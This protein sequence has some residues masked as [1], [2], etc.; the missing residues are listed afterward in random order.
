[1]NNRRTYL[2]MLRIIAC[3]LVIFNH[4]SGYLAYQHSENAVQ[5]FYY[6]GFTMFTRIN[7]P[8]FF[9]ISGSLLLSKDTSYKELFSKR[10][11]RIVLTLLCASFVAYVV[12]IRKNITSFDFTDFF[13]K[14]LSGKHVNAYWYLY[15]Y[16][17]FL[18]MLPLF[19]RIAK[20][21]DHKD[22]ILLVALHF[23]FF[24]FL[25]L[26]NYV[27]GKL[28]LPKMSVASDFSVP[29][30]NTKAL[31]YP[32]IGYYIDQVFDISKLNRK[33]V[34][35]LP[36]VI[37][38]GIAVSS[39]FTYYQGIHNKFT[40]DYVQSFDYTTAIAVFLLVK[41]IF[42]NSK[43]L[44]QCRFLH[45]VI[46]LIGSLTLGIYLM[47]PVLKMVAVNRFKKVITTSDPIAYSLIWCVFSMLVCGIVTY[48]LKKLPVIK[49]LL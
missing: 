14:L 6:M 10:I 36:G 32:L 18:L 29:L 15:A 17:A 39:V 33:N 22:F 41:Y 37:I 43:A 45:R 25:P 7:V 31:F 20:Q 2:D 47:D 42:T 38:F 4:L 12:S 8:I 30:A 5:A 27:L 21:F 13:T 34:W 19:R 23:V 9:M 11:L 44:S 46:T 24:T 3:F 49:K 40:Q 28:G 35:I 48:G 1:M 16:L 26:S